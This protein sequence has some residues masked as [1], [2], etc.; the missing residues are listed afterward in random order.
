LKSGRH[1]FTGFTLIEV[2][3]ALMVIAF[4]LAAAIKT[5]G[6]IVVNSVYLQDKTFAHWVAMNRLAEIQVENN[7]PPVGKKNGEE[8]MAGRE[9]QWR[10]EVKETPG[11]D[12]DMRR[13][14]IW[15]TPA[16]ADEESS[17]AMLTGFVK[18]PSQGL[19]LPQGDLP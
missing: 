4:A 8:E 2:L 17:V 9:W 7:W 3:V 11:R 12:R 16:G 15:V 14:D 1:R 10:T 19:G 6:T 13:I 5:T 18:R